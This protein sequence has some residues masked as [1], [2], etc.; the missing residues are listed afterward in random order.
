MT[1]STFSTSS[2]GWIAIATGVSGILAA[3]FLALMFSGYPAFGRFN[4]GMNSVLGILSA[5]LAA[6]LYAEHHARSPLLSQI[7][8]VLALVGAVFVIIGSVLIIFGYTGFVLAGWYSSLGFALIGLWLLLFCYSMLRGGV[9]PHNL[10]VV[11]LIVG[12]LMAFGLFAIAGILTKI[13]SMQSLPWF[14]NVALFGWLGILLYLIWTIW[15][16]RMLLK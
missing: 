3:V 15:L 10:I 14:L 11:G 2:T 12:G 8:L 1:T 6:M 7:A 5:L 9:F 16:G 13:D 4:D